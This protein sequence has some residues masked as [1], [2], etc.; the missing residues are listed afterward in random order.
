MAKMENPYI[1][2]ADGSVRSPAEVLYALIVGMK[3]VNAGD[4]EELARI[5]PHGKGLGRRNDAAHQ[6]GTWFNEVHVLCLQRPPKKKAPFYGATLDS[7][8][9]QLAM[10]QFLQEQYRVLYPEQMEDADAN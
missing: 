10:R 1:R 8:T 7:G 4:E 5:C 3:K 2:R 9:A 6:L